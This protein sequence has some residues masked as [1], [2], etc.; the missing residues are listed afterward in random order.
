MVANQEYLIV[1]APARKLYRVLLL[2]THERSDLA[3]ISVNME[4]SCTALNSK[5]ELHLL[6]GFC[7]TL[8]CSMSRYLDSNRSE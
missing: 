3:I 5:V 7:V 2:F 4:Q 8:W 6:D 1:L